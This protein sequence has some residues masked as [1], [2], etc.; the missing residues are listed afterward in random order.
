[1]LASLLPGLRDVRT[2]ITVGYLW[3]T[4][5]WVVW[6]DR[7]PDGRP[8]GDGLIARVYDVSEFLGN[9]TLLAALSFVAYILGA[10]VTIPVEGRFGRVFGSMPRLLSVPRTGPTRRARERARRRRL[11]KGRDTLDEFHD[12]LLGMSTDDWVRSEAAWRLEMDRALT[13]NAHFRASMFARSKVEDQL[14]ENGREL[15]RPEV[16]ALT[17]SPELLRPRL[18]ASG[19]T[20]VYGEYDRQA[21]EG[22]FRINIALPVLALGVATGIE[23]AWFLIPIALVVAALLLLQGSNRLE[24]SVATIQR[25][26]INKLFVHPWEE[27]MERRRERPSESRPGRGVL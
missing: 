4:F 3:L 10:I 27:A 12:F 20:E 9:T 22:S 16:E 19:R 5:A 7:I 2:P 15:S 8:N 23:V 1:M 21:A 17:A 13:G 25:A 26:A 18:L 6:G 14:R 24:A 11:L